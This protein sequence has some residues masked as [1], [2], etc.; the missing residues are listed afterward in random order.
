MFF[1]MD[2]FRFVLCWNSHKKMFVGT[3]ISTLFFLS[4]AFCKS[5]DIKPIPRLKI[6]CSDSIFNDLK[7]ADQQ[8]SCVKVLNLVEQGL[9]KFPLSITNFTNLTSLNLRMNEID[10]IPNEICR[11]TKLSS[12]ILAYGSVKYL[13]ECIGNLTNLKN[14]DLLDNDLETLPETIGDLKSLERLNLKGN[15]ITSLPK[16]IINLKNLKFLTV[17][18]EEGLCHLSAQ[19]KALILDNLPQCKTNFGPERE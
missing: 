19:E 14:L 5:K 3:I 17:A 8:K 2:F 12:I 15:K 4:F 9:T 13:P 16:S 10:S 18:D 11:L 7:L 6:E 1:E